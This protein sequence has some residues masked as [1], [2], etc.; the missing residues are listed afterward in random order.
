MPQNGCPPPLPSILRVTKTYPGSY[1]PSKGHLPPHFHVSPCDSQ[2][3]FHS[4]AN[5]LTFLLPAPGDS[6]AWKLAEELEVTLVRGW[7]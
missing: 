3:A 4:K 6:T 1:K 7:E 2:S 5:V